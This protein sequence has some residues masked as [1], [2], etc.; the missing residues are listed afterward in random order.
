MAGPG[1]RDT[2]KAFSMA[3]RQVPPMVGAVVLVLRNLV[4]PV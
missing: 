2:C 4:F 3:Q 1:H